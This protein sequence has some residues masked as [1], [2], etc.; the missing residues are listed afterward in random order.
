MNIKEL[1]KMAKQAQQ[2]AYAPYSNFKV[3]CAILCQN[4]EIV[5][6]CNIENIAGTSNCAERTAMF[7][8][9]A[10]GNRDFEMFAVI[11]DG[12]SYCYPCGTCRQIIIE[13]SPNATIVCAKNENDYQ[14]YKITELLPH[15]F[16]PD[17]LKK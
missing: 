10:K 12:K 9:I 1:I 13:H 7:S 6:G 15:S 16:Y 3:G 17:N 4:G 2:N 11:G 8:A 5:T 14:Q